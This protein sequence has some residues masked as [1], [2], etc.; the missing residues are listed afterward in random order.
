MSVAVGRPISIARPVFGLLLLLA[1]FAQATVLVRVPLQ[2]RPD[3]VVVLL[4]LWSARR[5]I[6]EGI[7]W[8]FGI[9][10][11]LDTLA[12]AR[13]GTSGLALLPA[14]LLGAPA[15]RRFFQSGLVVPLILVV[16]ATILHGL[17]LLLLRGTLEGGVMPVGAALRVIVPQAL[18]N[19][20]VTLPL[21]PILAQL[22][23][24]VGET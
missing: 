1:A 13:L 10:L 12:L 4:L 20:I 18:L 14:V 5:G 3:P 19:G 15:R 23:R 17:V 16:V 9:G 22:D 21:Y 6:G 7:V 8:A 24:L 11:V 2:V